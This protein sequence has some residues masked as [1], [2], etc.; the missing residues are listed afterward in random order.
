M[1]SIDHSPV[2]LNKKS[3]TS[4]CCASIDIVHAVSYSLLLLNTDLHVA[5]LSTRMSRS[6]F[7][8]NTLTA[9]QTQLAPSSPIVPSSSSTELGSYDD[10]SVRGPSEDDGG[11]TVRSKR[12]DSITSWNSVSRD[13][14][15]PSHSTTSV[16][17][18]S[19]TSF[20]NGNDGVMT[21]SSTHSYG[22]TWEL[23]MEALLKV[24]LPMAVRK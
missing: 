20:Q 23:E 7:V 19:T 24:S 10:C 1:G 9:I 17:N 6:Q 12:S 5:D 21:P 13:G 22:R 3:N 4:Y 15:P 16:V 2:S 11:R 14:V 18:S 8:R